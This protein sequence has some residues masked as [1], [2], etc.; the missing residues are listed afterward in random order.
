MKMIHRLTLFLVIALVSVPLV[1]MA[2]DNNQPGPTPP[3]K[4]TTDYD[5]LDL[6]VVPTVDVHPASPY[7]GELIDYPTATFSFPLAQTATEELIEYPSDPCK[8]PPSKDPVTALAQMNCDPTATPTR[9]PVPITVTPGTSIINGLWYLDTK[10]SDYSSSGNCVA[11]YGDNGGPDGESVDIENVP[12]FPVCMSSDRQWLTVDSG[13][14][15]PLV[16]PNFYSQQDMQ[17]ELI[18]TGGKTTGSVDVN[19][20]RQYQVIS[21]S[22]IEYSYT[23]Q[24]KG[25]CTTRSTVRYKLKEANDLVC[26]GVVM[27]PDYTPMPTQIPTAKPGETQVPMPTVEPPIRIGEYTIQLPPVDETCTA[28]KMPNS[29]KLNVGYDNNRNITI[30]IGGGSYTLF[31]DGGTYYSYQDGNQFNLS[32]VTYTGGA[33][34]AWSKAGCFINSELTGAGNGA[35]FPATATPQFEEPTLIPTIDVLASAGTV[36][37]VTADESA[38]MCTAE[39][40]SMLPDLAGATLTAQAD[41]TFK[42]S[43]GGVDYTLTNYGGAITYTQADADG[44]IF[45]ISVSDFTDGVG[46]GIIMALDNSKSCMIQLTFKP[47]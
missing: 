31:W 19:I 15:Y 21:P 22:E 3:P 29:N 42:F 1:I 47:Q 8:E 6:T 39:N 9:T 13:G 16:V 24:E 12:T 4:P 18:Y 41:N 36:Y 10:A 11:D 46:S 34:F 26:T 40:R 27:T 23:V 17:R 43:V 37:A 44:S 14:A 38:V 33:S 25:G 32:M 2:Q 28:D 20:T 35:G 30:N 5:S 7:P 45:S